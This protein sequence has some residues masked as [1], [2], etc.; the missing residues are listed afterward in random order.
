MNFIWALLQTHWGSINDLGSLSQFFA[1]LEKV[2]LGSDKPDYHTLLAV[3][4][5]I[6]EGLILNVWR[7]EC[8]NLDAYASS[9]P[10]AENILAKSHSIL[11]NYATP[12]HKNEPVKKASHPLNVHLQIPNLQDNVVHEKIVRLTRDLLYVAELINAISSGDFGRIEDMLSDLACMFWG[13]GSN[14]YSTE[15]LHLLFNIK[16]IWTPEFV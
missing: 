10:S 1:I 9:N 8:G 12:S 6:L 15:I 5:Q 11:K 3:L 2:Q 13:A 16:E 14:N 4:T 7:I